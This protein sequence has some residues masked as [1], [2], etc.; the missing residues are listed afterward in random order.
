[1]P[2]DSAFAPTAFI[3]TPLRRAEVDVDPA[4][5]HFWLWWLPTVVGF[6][7]GGALATV[8]A[9]PVEALPAAALGG[10]LAGAVIGVGQWLVLRHRLPRAGWWLPTTA[11]AQGVVLAAGA[12]LV[13]YQ[14]GSNQRS[15]RNRPRWSSARAVAP[16]PQPD[17]WNAFA[18]VAAAR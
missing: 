7:A 1:M 5:W 2:S 12:T 4:R 13:G 6:I 9:G 11:V 14:S 15:C 10:V 18:A 3:V 17:Q 8:V 16:C